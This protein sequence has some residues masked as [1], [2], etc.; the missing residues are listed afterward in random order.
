[1][2][3]MAARSSKAPVGSGYKSLAEHFMQ[4]QMHGC[5][6]LDIKRLDDV[7]GIEATVMRHHACWYMPCEI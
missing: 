4:F 3:G 6:P 1:M 2:F 7:D 5:M